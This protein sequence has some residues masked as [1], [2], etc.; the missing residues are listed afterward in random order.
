MRLRPVEDADLDA[1]YEHQSDRDAAEL[2]DVPRRDRPAFD[3][4]WAR[5]RSDPETLIRT[6]ESRDGVAGYVFMFIS[7]GRRV[8]GYWLGRE[9]WGRGLATQALAEFLPLVEERPL[10][11]TVAPANRASVRVLEK[12]GFRPLREEPKAIL[13]ELRYRRPV[14]RTEV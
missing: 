10:Y 1:F 8:V 2:A 4:H 7:D 14:L 13:F 5:I 12:N 6:I 11:A 9:H 3:Q